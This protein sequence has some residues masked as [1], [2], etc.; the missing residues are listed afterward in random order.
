[1]DQ[2]SLHS[3]VL[4]A[5]GLQDHNFAVYGD[6]GIAAQVPADFW[7]QLRDAMAAEFATGNLAGGII[8][9]VQTMGGELARHFPGAADDLNELPD[10]IVY[11]EA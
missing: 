5:F 2:T 3:G 8:L 4:L 6:A 10:A 1:M 7:E 11:E 9:A